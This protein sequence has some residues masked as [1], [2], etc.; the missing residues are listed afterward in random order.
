[1]K[2]FM[3]AVGV[4]AVFSFAQF[5]GFGGPQGGGSVPNTDKTAD[6][7]YVGD[8]KGYHTLDI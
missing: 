7:N 1:M 6:V 3:M 4:T 2:K 8:G 5:G